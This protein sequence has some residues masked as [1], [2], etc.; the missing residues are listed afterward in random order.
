MK[1]DVTC[2]AKAYQPAVDDLDSRAKP[3]HLLTL[4]EEILLFSSVQLL[5]VAEL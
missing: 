2:Y 3:T 1:S 5:Y 4:R